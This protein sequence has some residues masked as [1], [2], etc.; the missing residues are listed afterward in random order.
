MSLRLTCLFALIVYQLLQLNIC[1]TA[2][3]R[4]LGLTGL[5]FSELRLELS[6]FKLVTQ[7]FDFFLIVSHQTPQ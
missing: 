5:G 3:K 2:A 4:G 7:L 1:L 6:D